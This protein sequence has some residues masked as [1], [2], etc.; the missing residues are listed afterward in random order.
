M[1]IPQC[2]GSFSTLRDG[3]TEFAELQEAPSRN[4]KNLANGMMSRWEKAR[5]GILIYDIIMNMRCQNTHRTAAFP[6]DRFVNRRRL[7]PPEGTGTNRLCPVD[8]PDKDLI[9]YEQAL[10]GRSTKKKKRGWGVG[11]R[12]RYRQHPRF[13]STRKVGQNGLL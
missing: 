5:F 6:S 9:G 4:L 13:S 1:T 8:L 10:P 2:S 12:R 11:V 3:K 7:P